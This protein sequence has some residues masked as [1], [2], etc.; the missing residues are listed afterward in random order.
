MR[1]LRAS[2]KHQNL[3]PRDGVSLNVIGIYVS[4]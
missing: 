3:L 1:S 4:L 2:E